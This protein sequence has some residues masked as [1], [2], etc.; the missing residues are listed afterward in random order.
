M[1]G[2]RIRFW[3]GPGGA[4]LCERAI[5]GLTQELSEDSARFYGG[6][7]FVGETIHAG[8]AK[9]IAEAFDGEFLEQPPPIDWDDWD[10]FLEGRFS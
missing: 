4:L 6:K 8:A 10:H 5:A 3:S 9:K 1:S 7:H 2:Q